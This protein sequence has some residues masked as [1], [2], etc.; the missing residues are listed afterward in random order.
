M[1][2]SET[3]EAAT[4]SCVESGL[5][6]MSTASAPPA[7]RARARLAV[8]VVMW[9]QATSFTP[10]SGFSSANRSRIK[11]RTGISRSA[12]SMRCLPWAAK[13]ISFTSNSTE[14]V[15]LI[16]DDSSVDEFLDAGAGAQRFGFIGS[17]P[18]KAFLVAAEVSVSRGC[19]V[20]RP[21]QVEFLN[22]AARSQFKIITH[23]LRDGRFADA[24][25]AGGIDEH[26]D[27]IRDADR[28]RE[29]DQTTI[30]K[31]SGDDV[32]RD[33]ARHVSGR[34]IDLRR[35]FARESAAT[36]R[37]VTTVSVD[38]DLAASQTG[39]A[40]WPSGDKASG[41]ID[42]ILRVLVEQFGR[43]GVLDDFLFDLGAQLFVADVR[44]VLRRDDDG[45]Q[46]ERPA[47]AILNSHLRF[48][49]WPQIR[50]LTRFANLRQTAREQ[51]R[52]LNR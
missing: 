28:V 40:L 35:V 10:L 26:R 45:F 44:I 11:R 50:Q 47:V 14:R 33:V 17:F 43:D 16:F 38:N 8:S 39:I 49:I 19:F 2:Q 52:Q 6:A 32:L 22:D 42:V 23:E 3:S 48:S 4:S 27:G 15:A 5:E 36:V 29:L 24:S 41:R 31:T 46:A 25:G 12:H 37:R 20:N 30:G 21:A 9:A 18:G 13:P 1:P 51:V 34:A 7:C